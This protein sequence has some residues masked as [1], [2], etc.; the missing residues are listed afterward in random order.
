MVTCGT[1]VSLCNC[2]IVERYLVS[3]RHVRCTSLGASAPSVE[4]RTTMRDQTLANDLRQYTSSSNAYSM[5]EVLVNCIQV[6]QEIKWL[7]E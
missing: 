6:A 4:M 3:E 7:F 5:S 1:H 2:Y